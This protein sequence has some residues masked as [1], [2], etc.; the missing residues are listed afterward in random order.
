MSDADQLTSKTIEPLSPDL[1]VEQFGDALFRYAMLH[2]RDP[3]LAEDLVQE[4]FISAWKA[5]T[6]YAG[7]S[8]PQTWLMGILRHKIFDHMRKQYR[9]QLILESS[10]KTDEESFN[11][12]FFDRLDHWKQPPAS[13]NNPQAALQ[14][15]EFQHVLHTCISN[16]PN[17]MADAFILRVMDGLS[18]EEVCNILNIS[19]TNL[20]VILHRARIRL[21]QCLQNNWFKPPKRKK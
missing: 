14:E 11:Q 18:T 12:S 3:H 9:E 1:W 2:L 5:R 4:T 7:Q 17:Y 15:K 6:S 13:W 21:Q 16:L 20:A 10:L 19:S 8:K